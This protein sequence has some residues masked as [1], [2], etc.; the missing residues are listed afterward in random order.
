MQG[1]CNI[2]GRSCRI[3]LELDT[4]RSYARQHDLS[5]RAL[6]AVG[7]GR[8]PHNRQ[9]D[10]GAHTG[11]RVNVECDSVS[12]INGEVVEYT[13]NE[14]DNTCLQHNRRLQHIRK[15]SKRYVAYLSQQ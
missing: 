14:G 1:R 11:E 5:T 9:R 4:R 6:V 15:K 3:P 7:A 13:I 8:P 2:C 10:T 12:H